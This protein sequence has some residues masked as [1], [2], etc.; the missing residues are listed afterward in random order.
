MSARFRASCRPSRRHFS[1]RILVILGGLVV[2]GAMLVAVSLRG[3]HHDIKTVNLTPERPHGIERRPE[4]PPYRISKP[5]D[6]Q[7]LDNASS[8]GWDSEVVSEAALRQLSLLADILAGDKVSSQRVK[9]IAC[10]DISVEPLLPTN[11]E[12]D[13]VDDELKV[14]RVIG[15]YRS[16]T[17][18]GLQ[19][20]VF[21]LQRLRE[22]FGEGAVLQAKFKIVHIQKTTDGSQTR[23]IGSLVGLVDGKPKYEQHFT[24]TIDWVDGEDRAKMASVDV[25][26]FEQVSCLTGKPLLVDCTEAVIGNTESYRPQFL[27]GLNHWLERLQDMSDY[28]ILGSPGI[29]MGDVNGDGLEDLYVCQEAGLPNRLFL[30]QPDGT[31]I[32]VSRTAKVDW[33]ERTRSA[34]LIDIDND[35]DQDLV[36]ALMGNILAAA[37]DGAGHFQIKAVLPCGRDTMSLSAADYDLDGDLDIYVCVHSPPD[38]ALDSGGESMVALGQRIVYHDANNA[39]ANHLFRNDTVNGNWQFRDVTQETGLDQNNR[40]FSFSAAWEDYDNDGDQDLYVANDFGRNN[41]FRNDRD[42]DGFVRFVDVA[43]ETDTEDSASG[44]SV[45]WGDFDCDGRVDLYVSN[46]FSAAGSRITSDDRFKS[47]SNT[48]I[49]QRLKRFAR[50]NTLMHNEPTGTF[51]D[52]SEQAAVTMG[53][54]AWSSNFVD[55]NNDGR[56]D[57]VVANGFITGQDDGDL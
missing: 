32:E 46:M 31:A 17:L 12:I 26:S 35:G 13:F 11:L 51:L 3:C 25:E 39:G 30:H 54:W 28:A 15:P 14:E 34:L 16:K 8:D 21:E 52:V 49:R 7:Q 2:F 33:L 29:A 45:T 57:L 38:P 4:S 19:N 41:L 1:S 56:E 18:S 53:R 48:E 23:Q 44:M 55:L 43:A 50:G 5:I 40:R 22:R 47:A 36:A 42:R 24:W 27:K 10:D 9:A 6:F 20:F 37:N